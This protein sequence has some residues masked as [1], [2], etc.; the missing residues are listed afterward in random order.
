MVGPEFGRQGPRARGHPSQLSTETL[1]R[2]PSSHSGQAQ[3]L[4]SL[5]L[6]ITSCSLCLV[7]AG[8]SAVTSLSLC[9]HHPTAEPAPPRGCRRASHPLTCSTVHRTAA[10]RAR[11]SSPWGSPTPLPCVW[12]LPAIPAAERGHGT[13]LLSKKKAC[14]NRTFLLSQ[15]HSQGLLQCK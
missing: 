9:V 10:A 4:Y 15:T 12:A 7:N 2:A 14:S 6:L 3:A 8:L 13:R 11:G 1:I 5:F